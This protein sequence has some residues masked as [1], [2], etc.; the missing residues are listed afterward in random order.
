MTAPIRVLVAD[1][2]RA[3]RQLIARVLRRAGYTV[4]EVADGSDVLDVIG[5]CLLDAGATRPNIIVSDIRMPGV[6]G[7]Q[8]VASLRALD[9]AIPTILIT[10]FGDAHTHALATELGAVLVLDKPFD[11]ATLCEA[12]TRFAGPAIAADVTPPPPPRSARSASR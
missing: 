11:I 4:A 3:L 8:I 2:D 9:P 5:D 7:L 6:T 10:A 1:D 12:I